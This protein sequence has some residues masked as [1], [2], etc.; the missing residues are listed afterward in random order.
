MSH[1]S[2]GFWEKFHAKPSGFSLS[3]LV[4]KENLTLKDFQIKLRTKVDTIYSWIS[5][6]SEFGI[7]WILI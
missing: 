3:F 5:K 6:L 7:L 1:T 4:T 2:I